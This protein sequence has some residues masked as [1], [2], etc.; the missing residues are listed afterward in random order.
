MASWA[1]GPGGQAFRTVADSL[2]RLRRQLLMPRPD[3]HEELLAYWQQVLS[4]AT[5]LESVVNMAMTGAPQ[6][7]DPGAQSQWNMALDHA[8]YGA[9][10]LRGA[11]TGKGSVSYGMAM[12]ELETAE[13][14]IGRLMSQVPASR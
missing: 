6:M 4:R 7:P 8:Q 1:R 2:T 14:Y 11:V 5:F 13:K 3:G 10:D 12:S 9:V